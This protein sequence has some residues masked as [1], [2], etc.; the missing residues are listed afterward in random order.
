M[1]DYINIRGQ[2]IEVVASDPANPTVGQ[3]W[4]NSTSNTLK[5]GSVT[6]AATWAT[7]GN[8]SSARVYGGSFGGANDAV[9]IGG[10]NTVAKIDLVEEYNGTSWTTATALPAT[11]SIMSGAG[12]QTAGLGI[13]GQLPGGNTGNTFT[14]DG[15]TW[16]PTGTM[17][18]ARGSSASGG[19][20]TAAFVAGG[21]PLS[22]ATENFNGTSWT[23]TGNL[24]TARR[25]L[26]GGG[27][28]TAGLAFGGYTPAATAATEEWTGA[29]A[30]LTKTITV[31]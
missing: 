18:T 30:P 20:Q 8:L 1:A 12:S 26:G 29:G 5:G 7:G 27:T 28:Q 14:Y 2:S 10:E 11:T 13:G 4:Y 9:S 24:G 17:A 6:T 21:N 16:S 3:I 22:N 15:S 31:S 25:F 19:I 23:T